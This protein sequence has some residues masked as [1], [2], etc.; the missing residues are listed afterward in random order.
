MPPVQRDIGDWTPRCRRARC[1]MR[2][3][4]TSPAGALIRCVI[5]GFFAVATMM[6][7][8]WTGPRG[9]PVATTEL[10]S[11]TGMLLAEDLLLWSPTMPAAGCPCPRLPP[12]PGSAAGTSWSGP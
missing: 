5:A 1:K 2:C 3:W 9:P 12:M 11:V 10:V 4:A 7:R 8:L 6:V